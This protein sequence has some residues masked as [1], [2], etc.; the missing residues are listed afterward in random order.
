MLALLFPDAVSES[1]V[2]SKTPTQELNDL[3][4]GSDERS[5]QG[6][7]P[8]STNPGDMRGTSDPRGFHGYG[9]YPPRGGYYDDYHPQQPGGRDGYD[10]FPP[11]VPPP[12]HGYD[13]L[14][15]DHYDQYGRDP[16]TDL[17]SG[18]GLP[19][20]RE[21]RSRTPG[22]EFMRGTLPDEDRYL[23]HR[24]RELRSK[25]PTAELQ[26]SGGFHSSNLSGTP[27]FIPASRYANH[28]SSSSLTNQNR[29][30]NSYG[31][32]AVM[33]SSDMVVPYR[34][35]NNHPHHSRPLSGPDFSGS[36]GLGGAY[37]SRMNSS[38]T[39]AGS[40]NYA[41]GRNYENT[42]QPG[43]GGY[44]SG[45]PPRKQSTS[46]ENEEPIP[47]NLTRVPVHPRA[48]GV[49]A[50][51]ASDSPGS[52]LNRSR[53]PTR[54]GGEEGSYSEMTVHLKR[55]EKGFG[56][57]IIGGTEEGSQVSRVFCLNSCYPLTDSCLT[58]RRVTHRWV[59]LGDW[60]NEVAWQPTCHVDQ[61]KA[62]NNVVACKAKIY[63]FQV[64]TIPIQ[65]FP[66]NKDRQK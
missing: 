3:G 23:Q 31:G 62:V 64:S 49:D 6:S 63:A 45:Y 33:S 59:G 60:Q 34:H 10:R 66:C 41:G 25:T 37:P 27:D 13:P 55:E 8:P 4:L 22:P 18:D 52:S 5:R 1:T 43:Y 30:D 2:R 32:S 17:T 21:T 57:R 26:G 40:L 28:P 46:F 11:A 29:A 54:F 58:G 65:M 44:P 35:H 15:R 38:Q 48:G 16:R 47:S 50:W 14:R 51:G 7:R 12:P 36:S 53:S 61:L 39:Y 19:K 9:E 24:N 56:F 42:A 20:P